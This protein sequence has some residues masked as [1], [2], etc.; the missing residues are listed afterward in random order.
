MAY[1]I[2][3][4]KNLVNVGRSVS[5]KKGAREFQRLSRKLARLFFLVM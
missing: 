4:T 3:Q 1:N 5:S 2:S